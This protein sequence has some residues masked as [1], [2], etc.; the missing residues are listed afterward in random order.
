MK[1]AGILFI[2]IIF[3]TS[4]VK[5]QYYFFDDTYY[6]NKIVLEVGISAG[7]M[8]CLTDLGGRKGIGKKF[9]KDLT[10]KTTRPCGS[11]YF[12]AIY[13]NAIALR[14]EGTY[15]NVTAYDSILKKDAAST[16]GRYE[17][18]LSFRSNIFE[19]MISGEFHPF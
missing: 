11:I 16:F 7:G 19:L 1:P 6:D 12:S 17:R 3:F 5:A 14:I 9:I 2:I 4:Q 18:N 13:Q 15:G 8:N 10:L